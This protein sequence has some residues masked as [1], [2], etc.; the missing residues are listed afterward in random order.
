MAYDLQIAAATV[1]MEASGEPDEGKRGVVHV[2]VNRLKSGRWGKTLAA[3]CL[4][5]KQFSC[6]NI[7]DPN[8]KRMA[9]TSDTFL[10]YFEQLVLDVLAGKD[11]DPTEGAMWYLNPS[12]CS[13]DWEKDYEKT[14]TLGH[15]NFYKEKET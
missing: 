3:V 1:F 13:P 10:R 2:L 11:S 8:R 12:L 6:W 9:E 14:A 15:Q 4:A 5:P 7:A